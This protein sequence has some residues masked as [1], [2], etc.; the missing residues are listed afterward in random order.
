MKQ[1]PNKNFQGMTTKHS[2]AFCYIF[3]CEINIRRSTDFL[4]FY[5][6]GV[7]RCKIEIVVCNSQNLKIF[8]SHYSLPLYRCSY[9]A[10]EQSHILGVTLLIIQNNDFKVTP[11]SYD[12]RQISM[13]QQNIYISES[14]SSP[15]VT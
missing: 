10:P 3:F 12:F 2:H 9:K 5:F 7:V 14:A 13:N 8:F 1:P 6:I 11:S 15:F 4:T